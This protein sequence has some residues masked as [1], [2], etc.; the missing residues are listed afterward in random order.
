MRPP[1]A[2]PQFPGQTAASFRSMFVTSQVIARGHGGLRGRQGLSWIED[3]NKEGNEE[4]D[5][6]GVVIRVESWAPAADA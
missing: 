6:P 3:N 5:S 2:G 1:P 4:G